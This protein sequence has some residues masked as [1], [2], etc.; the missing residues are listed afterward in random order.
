MVSSMGRG[1]KKGRLLVVGLLLLGLS[2]VGVVAASRWLLP[3][4]TGAPGPPGGRAELER[5]EVYGEVPDFA[6]IERSGRRITRADLLGKVW[7]TNFI[8]TD[9]TETCPLQ[10][11]HLARLQA[12]LRGE[13]D[14]RLVSITV[15]PEH[16]T[17]E[18]LAEY[19][20][21]YRA[22]P[23]RWLFLT[24]RREVIYRLAID[25]FRLGVADSALAPRGPASALLARVGP[26]LGPAPAWAHPEDRAP[27]MHSSRFVVVDRRARIRGYFQSADPEALVR[28]RQSLRVL[29]KEGPRTAGDLARRSAPAE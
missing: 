7:I 24:G 26:L 22:D 8:Y 2:G 27:I 29:L 10:S 25:G 21:R 9:C 11:A 28:L 17:P 15:D 12:E 13:P 20:A 19:A 5:L 14:L 3:G 23:G 16:D 4:P 1:G 6:L 18:V